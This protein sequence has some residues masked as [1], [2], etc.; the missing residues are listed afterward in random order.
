V[1]LPSP[2]HCTNRVQNPVRFK[3]GSKPDAIIPDT[4]GDTS[5]FN[6]DYLRPGMVLEFERWHLFGK[7]AP[8]GAGI[9]PGSMLDPFEL[10][11]AFIGQVNSQYFPLIR[12]VGVWLCAGIS[13]REVTISGYGND[14]PRAAAASYRFMYKSRKVRGDRLFE[15]WHPCALFINRADRQ[16]P[17]EVGE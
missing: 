5:T 4:E 10:A 11:S 3:S 2:S 7:G 8:K 12:E 9:P 15:T 14:P 6:A 13:V 17:K 16:V 1:P